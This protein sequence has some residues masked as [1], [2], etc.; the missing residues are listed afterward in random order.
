MIEKLTS[1]NSDFCEMTVIPGGMIEYVQIKTETRDNAYTV[2]LFTQNS[3]LPYPVRLDV[4]DKSITITN[5]PLSHNY[6]NQIANFKSSH[7]PLLHFL[8]NDSFA[9]EKTGN[10]CISL[11]FEQE[12]STLVA[13]CA[14]KCSSLKVKGD[15]ILSLCP[16]VEI[17]ALCIDDRYRFQGIGQSIL[18]HILYQI[19]TIRNVVGVQFITLFAVQD[20]MNFYKKLGFKKL[21]HAGK[22]LFTSAHLRCVPMYITLPQININYN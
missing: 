3:L 1:E 10:A 16:S 18:R 7:L 13:F 6:D 19:N 2:N 8:K 21:G 4:L 15:K 22:V 17:A 14:T 5:K 11:F 20:A 9:C 12:T